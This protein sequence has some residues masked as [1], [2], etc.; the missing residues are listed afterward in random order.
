VKRPLFPLIPLDTYVW[1]STLKRWTGWSGDSEQVVR[2]DPG[3]YFGPHF[4]AGRDVSTS[5]LGQRKLTVLLYLDDDFE[6][7]ATSFPEIDVEIAPAAGKATLFHNL[8]PLA[9]GADAVPHP[10]SLHAGMPVTR[11]VKHVVN[12][13][14]REKTYLPP[15]SLK[16]AA[17]AAYLALVVTTVITVAVVFKPAWLMPS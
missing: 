13:W 2:Y 11:G 3:D 15:T 12:V 8:Q 7:G 4:D 16:Y 10:L 9:G 5:W 1:A 14:I 6:G 17:V